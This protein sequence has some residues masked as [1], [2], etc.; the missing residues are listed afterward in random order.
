MEQMA[1]NLEPFSHNPSKLPGMAV[2]LD[3]GNCKSGFRT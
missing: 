2:D 1:K 3:L